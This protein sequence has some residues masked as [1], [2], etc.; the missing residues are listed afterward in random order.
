MRFYA[1]IAKVDA[2]Q[3]MVWGYA[4]TE[5]EDDQGET[6]TR[7]AL[8]AALAD[9]LRFANIR[10]MHQM[11]A[12]GVAEEAAIDDRGL[13]V[14]AR[15][16]DPRAWDKVATGVYKGFSIGGRVK[17]RNPGDR[18][19]ITGLS[20][21]EISLVDRPANPEAVFDC[22]K[23]QG[24]DSMA[25]AAAAERQPVQLWHCGIAA[26][27]HLAK[28]E[29]ARCLD[30]R[31]GNGN[32]DAE[33]DVEYA[34][35]GYQPDGAKR[36]PI[37]SESHIRA[38]WAYIHQPDNA[39]RYSEAQLAHIKARIAAAW[40]ER[41][42][43]AGPPATAI[44]GAKAASPENLRKGVGELGRIGQIIGDLD[45]LCGF[46]RGMMEA[47]MAVPTADPGADPAKSIYGGDLAK[48][49]AGEIVP[50]LDALAK[51][52][53][54]IA[55]TPLPPQIAARGYAAISK[56]DD[57]VVAPSADDV[58]AALS[59]MSDEDRTLALIK[60]AHANPIRPIDISR[61]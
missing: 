51:R 18:T 52:V 25:D 59:R 32:D 19:I 39:A 43:P 44:G 48:T 9:Y 28:A 6:I 17:S 16:V 15:I 56:G 12:V 40:Q 21:T 54:D 11:S 8:A 33:N 1:P 41:V 58:V 53:E 5:A 13:Y 42:D 37:D 49:F 29:A 3:H 46:L 24:G 31:A 35:P 36:Y 57:G 26:H 2:A 55:A 30:R 45:W 27:R 23:A 60:A 61:G 38:A 20:L 7:D 50:R 14:G 34:D 10:E 47:G 22:W 4:S